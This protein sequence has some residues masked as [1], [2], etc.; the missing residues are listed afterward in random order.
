[1]TRTNGY[2]ALRPVIDAACDRVDQKTEKAFTNHQKK[3][4]QERTIWVNVFSSEQQRYASE[5]LTPISAALVA[6]GE[7]PLDVE[8]IADRY[9]AGMRR[10]VAV[11][12][13]VVTLKS[14]LAEVIPNEA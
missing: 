9:S 2:S 5:A 10:R 1:P 12:A 4:D 14:L 3:P 7:A 13:E 6:M 8:K 11:P